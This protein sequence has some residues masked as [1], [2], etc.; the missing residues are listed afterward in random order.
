MTEGHNCEG[1]F[2]KARAWQISSPRSKENPH[3][4]NPG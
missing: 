2:R 4:Y 1:S 3:E